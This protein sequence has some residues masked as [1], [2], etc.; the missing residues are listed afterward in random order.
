VIITNQS[1]VGRGIISP[2]QATEIN[3]QLLTVIEQ[4]GGRIDAVFMCIHAP[5]QGC[6]C[7]KPRPGLILQAASELKLDLQR[8]YLIGDALSDI[9]AGRN[10]GITRNILVK[11]GRGEKQSR[12]PDATRLQPFQIFNRFEDA[13]EA[14][15]PDFLSSGKR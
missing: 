1:A 2:E 3:D 15:M 8:S 12:L 5:Q 10:A 4:A 7:R 13:V 11:T 14:L 6:E 9:Q